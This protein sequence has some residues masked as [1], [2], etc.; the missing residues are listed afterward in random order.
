M[1][2]IVCRTCKFPLN[3]H[4]K[5]CDGSWVEGARKGC[6]WHTYSSCLHS[7][8]QG[9]ADSHRCGSVGVERGGGGGA[10]GGG[11]RPIWRDV[12]ASGCAE[13][14]KYLPE[15]S[16]GGGDLGSV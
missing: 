9:S 6:S 5:G 2:E 11:A 3:L 7:E 13:R 4:P 12:A 1:E 15:G 14:K 8:A 16:G 10:G